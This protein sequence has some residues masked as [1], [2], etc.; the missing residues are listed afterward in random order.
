MVYYEATYGLAWTFYSACV[1][2]FICTPHMIEYCRVPAK[3]S[4]TAWF[5][6]IE[7]FCV[8]RT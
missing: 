1:G 4:A 6:I 7:D 8:G 2:L 5:S 3:I